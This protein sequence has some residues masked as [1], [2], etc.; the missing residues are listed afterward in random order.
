MSDSTTSLRP[1][2]WSQLPL[3]WRFGRGMGAAMAG[4][5][6]LD[7][8]S[9]GIVLAQP[10]VVKWLLDSVTTGAGFV[11]G[12]IA[13]SAVAVLSGVLLFTSNYLLG[14]FGQRIVLGARSDMIGALLRARVVTVQREPVGDLLS[15]VGSDTT[16]LERAV[17]EALV[18][19]A[20]APL[21]LLA[22]VLLMALTDVTMV[23]VLLAIV[24][25]GAGIEWLVLRRLHQAT[26][27]TQSSVGEMLTGL[28][29]VLVAFRTVK[30][31]GTEAQEAR[32]V[33][34]RAEAAYRQGVRAARWSA[35]VGACSGVIM[36]V[37]FLTALGMGAAKIAAGA[38]SFSDLVAFLLYVMYLRAPVGA[39][40]QAATAVSEGLAALG[41]VQ[42]VL[43]VPAEPQAAD[44]DMTPVPDP[45]GD[46]PPTGIVLEKVSAGYDGSTV[47]NG[48]TLHVPRGLTVITG[49]SGI[50]KTTLLNLV[51]RFLDAEQ[52]RVFLDGV[53]IRA[54]R[55][56]ALRRRLAYV[57]QDAPLLGTTI[58]QAVC[59]G[60][61]CTD[62]G[63]A[64]DALRAVGLA[65]WLAGL[66]HGLDTAVDERAVSVSGGQ[67]QRL[68]VARALLR[69][70]DVL[71][72]DEVTSQLDADSEEILLRTIVDRS[73]ARV[74]LAVTHRI[75]V[76]R[77][78]D[79]VVVLDEGRVRAAGRHT[80]LLRSDPL[81]RRLA[82]TEVMR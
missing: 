38:L 54:L 3:L 26:R 2:A 47:L 63:E 6:V 53:D 30:A 51:E 14:R 23:L 44:A 75:S 77:Q 48:I 74:V 32:G 17:A 67:R 34:G 60:T 15:R 4:L 58:R 8:L 59:Y 50:G 52:G 20:G 5:L 33:V 7:L 13:L 35:L 19:G 21:V 10:R 81:Y 69:R 40:T 49:P 31:F 41:R 12:L 24:A 29:R 71:L 18:R 22:T 45:A 68:A 55:R 1:S 36:D 78:A 64:L 61:G 42:R 76:A 72:L 27:A 28:Q 66:P 9:Y 79:L 62:D 57:E 16:L 11:P 37:M 82:T 25:L 43:A 65:E 46:R 56:S 73:R 70:A 39:M 80:E